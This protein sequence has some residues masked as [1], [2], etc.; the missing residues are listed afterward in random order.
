MTANCK[1]I[2]ATVAR[3]YGAFNETDKHCSTE[4]RSGVYTIVHEHSSTGEQS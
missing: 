3:E 2:R 1:I 4:R